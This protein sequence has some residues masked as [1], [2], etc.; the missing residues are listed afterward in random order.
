MVRRI[1]VSV[2]DLAHWLVQTAR[3]FFRTPAIRHAQL[4]LAYQDAQKFIYDSTGLNTLT[5][6]NT[7]ELR[8]HCLR[9]MPSEGE[10]F[11]FGVYKGASINEIAKFLKDCGDAREVVGFDSFRGFSE[12]WSGVDKD[13]S[14]ELFDVSGNRPKVANNVSLV[15]GFIENSLPAYLKQNEIGSVAF[16]HIDTDTYTPA[17][18]ALE[19][20]R[21]F[22]KV[23]SIILFDELCGYPN[24]RSHEYRAL[25]EVLDKSEYEFLGFAQGGPRSV[26][27][28]AGIRIIK[29]PQYV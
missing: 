20:L 5:F 24:W 27:I 26:L 4:E 16:V 25:T 11:E 9:E 22:L 2:Y 28:K 18:V 6:A 8:E 12:E 3:R 14:K 23:G 7:F 10:I 17:K 19:L 13:F 21:P 29:Q 15:D 1:L